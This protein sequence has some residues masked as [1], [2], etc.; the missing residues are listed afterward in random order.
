MRI[1]HAI[2]VYP[3]A[4]QYGG[5]V[6][7]VSRLCEA[8]VCA[9]HSVHVLTTNAGLPDL[10]Q[11]MFQR[12][13]I[14]NGV[15]INYFPVD[16]HRGIIR[17]KVM[18]ANLNHALNNA[19]ILHLSSI[20][21]PWANKLQRFANQ[22]GIPVL[23]SARGALS[24]YSFRRSWW[25][26]FPYYYFIQRPL[27]QKA[28]GI[29][30][31]SIQ[32]LHEVSRHKLKP[33]C[34]L[35]PNPVDVSLPFI[36]SD[37]RVFWRNH[38]NLVEPCRLLLVCG[39]QHHKKGLD[40]LPIL[41]SI[42]ANHQW[43][44]LLVGSDEDGSGFR[45]LRAMTRLG[46]GH[47]VHVLPTVPSDELA[48][49][50]AAADL[51]L[52]PSRHENFG[53]VVIEALACGCPVIISD[54]TGVAND[55]LHKAPS[56]FGMVVPRTIHHWTTWLQ[57]WFARPVIRANQTAEWVICH[58]SKEAVAQRAIDVYTTLINYCSSFKKV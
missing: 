37:Q 10:P 50:F 45:L 51:L 7:S 38:F 12:P 1:L 24:A 54:S 34:F 55:L 40:I 35:F 58:Y 14:R 25:K 27:L 22:A 16:S 15:V 44:L 28:L 5:P 48:G 43:F 30:V 46:L 41:L 6:L 56:D 23:Q 19:D 2:P 26:K 49:L 36:N 33:R 47:R 32:E 31:T 8:L 18:D 9:G 53:N 42:L 17:S 52:L 3:P 39:R 21:Q 57:A 13:V 4:W 20:W 29:H 11:S